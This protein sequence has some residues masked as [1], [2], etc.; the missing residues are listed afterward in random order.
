MQNRR[1]GVLTS[2]EVEQT[3]GTDYRT[4]LAEIPE[5]DLKY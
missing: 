4:E 5:N 2:A 3:S 1:I